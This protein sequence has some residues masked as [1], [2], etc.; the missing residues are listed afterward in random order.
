[1]RKLLLLLAAVAFAAPARADDPTIEIRIQ[2][3][4]NLLPLAPYLGGLADQAEQAEQGANLIQALAGKK[5]VIEGIDIT[6]PIGAYA[7]MTSAVIDSP[8]VV[9]VPVADETAFLN[10]LR[11]KLSL[12]PEKGDGD[13][14]AVEVPNVPPTVYFRFHKDYVCIT[15]HN[16]KSLDVKTLPD[17]KAFFAKQDAAVMAV[18]VHLD[19][20]PAD[21][22]KT[23]LGQMELKFADEKAKPETSPFEGKLRAIGLDA[24]FD[25]IQTVST[26]GRALNLRLTVDSKADDIGMDLSLTAQD[27]SDLKALFTDAAKRS[28]VAP[29]AATKDAVLSFAA[30]LRVPEKF[31]KRFADAIDLALGEAMENAKEN[32]RE[33]L[34]RFFNAIEP[35]LKAGVVQVGGA[36]TGTGDKHALVGAVRMKSGKEIEKLAKEF[37]PFIP[38]NQAKIKFDVE[39]A[40]ETPLHQIVPP[41]EER[42]EKL[43]GKDSSVWLTTSDDLFVAGFG[44]DSA[45][46]KKVTQATATPS[47]ILSFET[48]VGRLMPVVENQVKPEQM[49]SLLKDAFADGKVAGNDTV[50]FL[51]TGGEKLTM[52]LTAKGRALKLLTLISK[53]KKES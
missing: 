24:L 4:K 52:T 27:G 12:N 48:G 34:K 5:G 23:V 38:E 14:Y 37:A 11:G 33:G 13:V 29:L 15:V 51:V 10:L 36:L 47:P 32:D 8:I 17:P 49:K 16:K 3:I 20:V 9:L 1:M 6:R 19:R 44:E 18:A 39:K 21:V 45:A 50:K 22:R 28:A 30:N 35:T 31:Q 41:L 53:Q 2:S 7:V 26:E 25:G 43:F 42:A 46:V 40:G